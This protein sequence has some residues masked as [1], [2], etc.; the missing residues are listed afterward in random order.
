[1]E[2]GHYISYPS[3]AFTMEDST[4]VSRSLKEENVHTTTHRQCLCAPTTHE[5]SFRCRLH[6]SVQNRWPRAVSSA[7]PVVSALHSPT[8]S[9]PLVRI[10][11]SPPS[12]SSPS[13]LSSVPKQF[14]GPASGAALVYPSPP[15]S[16]PLATLPVRMSSSPSSACVS[17]SSR[18]SAGT[19][20]TSSQKCNQLPP[21]SSVSSSRPPLFRPS[22][23]KTVEAQ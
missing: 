19:S 2:G 9:T 21:R 4:S 11:S 14:S 6:R 7:V 18:S 17:S 16:L 1:M 5:G 12:P 15:S 23:R 8:S 13:P 22:A 10:S 3:T 20:F